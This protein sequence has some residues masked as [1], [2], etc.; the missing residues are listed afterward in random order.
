MANVS[1]GK[2]F[3]IDWKSSCTKVPFTFERLRDSAKWVQGEGSKF[4]PTNKADGILHK[5][6]FIWWLELKST[7][8]NSISFFPETPWIKPKDEK[9]RDIKASQ[10]KDLMEL[11]T[12]DG[13]I[14]G[15]VFNYREKKLKTKSYENETYFVHINDFVKFA[16]ESKKSSISREESKGIGV[17]I[18][19]RKKEK[20]YH[21]YVVD[22][23][24]EAIHKYV[25]CGYLDRALIGETIE[26]LEALMKL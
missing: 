1:A 26:Y 19:Y 20:Y 2:Q 8:D 5:M 6:P 17:E 18:K 11:T 4:T 10:A 22:F 24:D 9:N 12:K 14:A 3:E 7:A 15:F 21:Y 23:I 25:K 13:A 16:V